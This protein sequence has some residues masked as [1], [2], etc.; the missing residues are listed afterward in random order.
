MQGF[1]SFPEKT[2][3]T[4]EGGMTAIIGP[5]G[6]G[7]SNISD[8]IR[9]VLGEM[10]AKSL[11]GARMEDVIFNGTPK[12]PAANCAT[13]SLFLDTSGEYIA[14]RGVI[15]DAEDEEPGLA[16]RQRIWDAEEAVITRKYYRSGESEYYINK[17]QVRLKD[18]YEFFYDTGIGR[19]GY[20]VIGQGRIAEVLSVKG[21]ERRSI[22]EEASGISKFR[23]KKT[24]TERKLRDTD[25]NLDRVRDIF[26]EVSSRI[27]PLRKEAENAGKF[28]ALSEEKKKLE[29]TIWLQRIDMLRGDLESAES[30][31]ASSKLELDLAGDELDSI[32]REEDEFNEKGYAL[33]QRRS[34][35]DE[36]S[37]VLADESAGIIQSSAV[38]E[39]ETRH[40]REKIESNARE[41][42]LVSGRRSAS[43]ELAA[44]CRKALDEILASAEELKK[45]GE[46]LERERETIMLPASDAEKRRAEALAAI[47]A[48]EDRLTEIIKRTS[49]CRALIASAEKRGGARSDRVEES[50]ARLASLTG[51]R[52]ELARKESSVASELNALKAR[53][54]ELGTLIE[55]AEK[56]REN[57]VSKV[58]AANI[59]SAA[60]EQQRESLLRLERLFEGYS[61]SVK[62]VMRQ[63]SEGK[64]KRDGKPIDLRGTVA[65]LLSAEGEYVVAMETAL[66]ASVQFIVSG[67][68]KDAKTAIAY[69]KST[70]GGRITVLPLD[71]VK[72]RRCDV[73]R[74][75]DCSGFIGIASDLIICDAEYKCIA[76]E[77][78]GRT[79]I[80]EDLD[81]A[82]VMAAKCGYTVKI[83]TKDGQIINAGGSYTGG[84]PQKKVGIF[85]RSADIDKLDAEIAELNTALMEAEMGKR[86]AEKR[87]ASYREELAEVN[88]NIDSLAE[89]AEKLRT[90][91][92]FAE[93][94]RGEEESKL[95]GMLESDR[96][97]E[98]E[99]QALSDELKTLEDEE[100]ELRRAKNDREMDIIAAEEAISKANAAS[101][102]I[103]ADISDISM[104][105][106]SLNAKAGSEQEKLDAVCERINEDGEKLAEIERESE[107]CESNIARGGE[108]LAENARKLAQI[109]AEKEAIAAEKKGIDKELEE[110]ELTVPERKSRL[111]Q[112]QIRREQAFMSHTK[113]ETGKQAAQDEFDSVT[114]K[115]WDEY[116][117]TYSDAEQF[118]L[119]EEER[120]KMPTRLNSVKAKIRAMGVI[121]VKAVDEYRELKER[122]D[123]LN[124]QIDDLDRTRRKLDSEISRLDGKMKTV[125]LDTFARINTAFGRVFTELFGGGSARVELTDPADPLGCGIDIILHPPGKSVKSISLLSGGEQSFAAIALYLALQEI[126]PAPFCILDEIESALDE[127]NQAKLMD[128]I[129]AHCESTQYLLITHRRGTM[130]R[131][132]TLY[133]I[134][135]REKG[136]SEYLKLDLSTLGEKYKD[137]TDGKE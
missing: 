127:V 74:I 42:A 19:E 80:A 40:Y 128:Y 43:E 109:D 23:I 90:E 37:A 33:L 115:L 114:G 88:A 28:I 26:A 116:E 131:A 36:R 17:K 69:L 18:I 38:C 5:N 64:I 15:G 81:K 51:K 75:K 2:K 49:S 55:S 53:A 118:R 1:K 31:L 95:S 50:R 104:Q 6:S 107:E 136:V 89:D 67:S 14:H 20:S 137:Y 41:A 70:G 11:R 108:S 34:S 46:E 47:A 10:S 120:D 9:W 25:A 45:K 86:S 97:N 13:V 60:A 87:L 32:Q 117:L 102:S 73:S 63:A 85:T 71:T 98:E 54:V 4:F 78:L 24:E 121:N 61:D 133:G 91:L 83:V 113:L 57:S 59:R 58:S 124:A 82:S 105:L 44:S 126:N 132:D 123:F 101:E 68:E 7:K 21:D 92:S 56:E 77:L 12:R 52:D 99:K 29:V 16:P 8:S 122:Y 30:A 84:S 111:R 94:T 119:P 125:F 110:R 35:L 22:F 130:E 135:M 65:S 112:A 27:E 134:T 96:R 48:A 106:V 3:M 72:G 79:V 66:G 129:K 62:T 76:D 103:R 100:K 93:A 39:T